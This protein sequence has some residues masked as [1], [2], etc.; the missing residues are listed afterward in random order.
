MAISLLGKNRRYFY[1]YSYTRASLTGVP[2]IWCIGRG[3]GRLTL[4][5]V[6]TYTGLILLLQY[7]EGIR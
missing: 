3:S 2:S 6:C 4:L 5:P 7:N 1:E